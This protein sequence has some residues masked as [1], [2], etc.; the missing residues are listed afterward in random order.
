MLTDHCSYDVNTWLSALHHHTHTHT[1]TYTHTH[2]HTYTQTHGNSSLN[3][4][5]KVTR[6]EEEVKTSNFSF[7]NFISQE[8]GFLF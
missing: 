3:S 7:F 1:H 6:Q 4:M 8:G 5:F 2:T